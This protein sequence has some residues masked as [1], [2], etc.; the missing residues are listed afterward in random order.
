MSDTSPETPTAREYLRHTLATLAYRCGKV[1]RGV[2]ESFAAFKAG[3][4]ARTPI[5]ILAHIGDLLEWAL[6]LAKGQRK[7]PEWTPGT[8]AS[9]TARFHDKIAAFDRHLASDVPLAAS[10][11]KLF[12]G[13]V[14]DALTH[15]GQIAYLRRLA[16]IPIRGENYFVADVTTG[17]VGPEQ[18]PARFEFD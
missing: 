3:D 10:P 15:V 14:A 18:P 7:W 2:P 16:G 12:Q 4:G 17:C 6:G 13:P 11:E 8:W 1:T 5:E 9:E